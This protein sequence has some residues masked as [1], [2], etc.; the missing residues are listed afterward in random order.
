VFDG[1][2]G[3]FMACQNGHTEIVRVMV[4]AIVKAFEAG[5]ISNEQA[6]SF[7]TKKFKNNTPMLI[8]H[9]NGHTEIVKI[10]KDA[11]AELNKTPQ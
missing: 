2:S 6:M 5:R 7:L 9:I 1:V 11:M 3:L 4:D 8:A 10:I